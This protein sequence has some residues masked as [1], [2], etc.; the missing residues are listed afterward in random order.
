MPASRTDCRP[1]ASC[2]CALSASLRRCGRVPSVVCPTGPAPGLLRTLSITAA[3]A[4]G[5]RSSPGAGLLGLRPG[6][7]LAD[8]RLMLQCVNP[9]LGTSR[10]L[11][12]LARAAFLRRRRLL[13]A[14]DAFLRPRPSSISRRPSTPT[15]AA[16]SSRSNS[17]PN[18]STTCCGS[19]TSS[20]SAI[21]PMKTLPAYERM[22][23]PTPIDP[24]CGTQ[25]YIS[26][27]RCPHRYSGACGPGTFEATSEP[28]RLNSS[29][30]G[31]WTAAGIMPQRAEHHQRHRRLQ[32]AFQRAHRVVHRVDAL[33]RIA[34]SRPAGRRTPARTCCRAPSVP[35]RARRL[36]G[37]DARSTKPAVE[38][39][40]SRRWAPSA[41]ATVAISTSLTVQP[42]ALRLSSLRSARG[43]PSTRRALAAKPPRNG[44]CGSSG[45]SD[46]P[47]SPTMPPACRAS[48]PRCRDGRAGGRRIRAGARPGPA[49]SPGC[50]R[51]AARAARPSRAAGAIQPSAPW[52]RRNDAGFPL[53]AGQRRPGV[54]F[55]QRQQHVHHGDAVGVAVMQPHDPG[56]ARA[57][58]LDEVHL[59]ERARRVEPR[60][61]QLGCQR[62]QF[63]L[64]RGSGSSSRRDARRGRSRRPRPR[65]R[66]A[67]P[68]PAA[69]GTA[70]SRGSRV[71]ITRRNSARSSGV[72][73]AMTPTIIMELPGP[74]MRSHAVST[75]DMRS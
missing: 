73:V 58:A 43:V 61:R 41:P 54:L 2:C 68:R 28:L 51:R 25:K 24:L 32:R 38:V 26:A 55:G 21:M 7:I 16:S 72:A 30:A 37:T 62:L 23:T 53:R 33:Q 4:S 70:G 66:R 3:L 44:V 48:A 18:L 63:G 10:G 36:T 46:L 19:A 6:D 22:L 20:R 57:V 52:A 60:A 5:H 75:L 35:R 8:P 13:L 67:G 49:R 15:V 31:A 14:R 50:H 12:R 64:A 59:P 17:G 74:S 27:M 47:N 65:T 9:R 45:S 42:S 1:W 39:V 40:R 34:R 11:P 29:T 69:G 56:A 71:S